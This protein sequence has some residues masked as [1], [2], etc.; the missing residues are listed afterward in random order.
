MYLTFS[1]LRQAN[2]TRCNRW[3]TKAGIE[4]WT[5]SDWAV[6]MAG[7]A[8]EV[9]D[10]IKKLNRD[11]DGTVGNK[12]TRAE[13]LGDLANE[14]ADTA[15]YLDLLAARAGVDLAAAIASKFNEVSE[16]NGFPDRLPLPGATDQAGHMI[17]AL[18][19]SREDDRGWNL[20]GSGNVS[21]TYFANAV[22]VYCCAQNRAVSIDEAANVFNVTPAIIRQAVEQ[23]YFMF[24]EPDGTIGHEGE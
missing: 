14:I 13:L 18:D 20:E 22:Q 7:E 12:R 9:C 2:V 6:A 5:L 11:R 3:H 17:T 15:I 19:D 10:V 24:E 16:R 1:Q 8:G 21:A 4:E 23:H